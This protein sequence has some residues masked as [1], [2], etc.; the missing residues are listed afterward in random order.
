RDSGNTFSR[1][2][3]D[4]TIMPRNALVGEPV[5]R[6]DLRLLRRFPIAGATRVEGSLEVFNLFNHANYGSYVTADANRLYGQPAQE[7]ERGLSAAHA[8]TGIP[9]QLLTRMTTR[10]CAGRNRPPGATSHVSAYGS[11]NTPRKATAVL[12]F[13]RWSSVC[14]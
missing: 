11:G 4:G 8:P 5:H 6:V 10:G 1:L 12:V 13:R 2:R 7:H 9:H 3:P 14:C